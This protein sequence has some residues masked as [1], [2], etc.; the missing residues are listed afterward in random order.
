[1]PRFDNIT[2]GEPALSRRAFIFGAP[3]FMGACMIGGSPESK[4]AT[5]LAQD[6]AE[7]VMLVIFSPDGRREVSI[8]LGRLLQQ[9][10]TTIWG[11]YADEAGVFR[12]ADEGPLPQNALPTDVEG[13]EATFSYQGSWDARFERTRRRSAQMRGTVFLSAGLHASSD[14]PT[15]EGPLPALMHTGFHA[16]HAP[17]VVRPGRIEVFGRGRAMINVDGKRFEFEGLAKWHEQVGPRPAFGPAFT[18]VALTAGDNAFMATKSAAGAVGFVVREGKVRRVAALD[19]NDWDTNEPALERRI[20]ARLDDGDEFTATTRTVRLSSEPIEGQRRPGATV[21][22]ST[23]LG[24]MVGQINDWRPG[25]NMVGASQV[26]ID[27]H[28]LNKKS[29]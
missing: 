8:R 7:S 2:N 10:K 11:A 22:A 24:A 26:Y 25:N 20:S 18:Y 21:V 17:V 14:P 5:A 28:P 4:P 29:F 16:V 3:L 6:Y 1:M 27:P 13:D 19:I 15:G 9:Q 12:M 23:A